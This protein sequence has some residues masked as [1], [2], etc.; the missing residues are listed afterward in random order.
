MSQPLSTQAG[1]SS[2]LWDLLRKEARKLEGEID[3]KLAAYAKQ[4]SESPSFLDIEAQAVKGAE[5]E[6]L[7]Q[8]LTDVDDALA[9]A[10]SGGDARAHTLSRHRDILTEFTQEY[11]RVKN[12]LAAGRD[13][14]AL[15]GRTNDDPSFTGVHVHATGSASAAGALL[16]ER[17]TI[18]SSSTQ[19][20]EVIAQA[21]ANLSALTA[22]RGL[23]MNIANKLGTVGSKFPAINHLMSAIRR[24]KSK[25][26]LI[27]STVVAG[28][29]IFLLYYWL[30]K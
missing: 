4:G 7:L 8:R 5:I 10:V 21:Q 30:S 29:C 28:C 24:K 17:G 18:H 14:A 11:R 3:A 22:Q 6:A 9:N 23:F 1:T 16:R 15:L 25:D 19:L 27:L 20:E 12:N 2:S 13:H 26:T